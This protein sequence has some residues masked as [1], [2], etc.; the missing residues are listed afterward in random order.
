MKKRMYAS[1]ALCILLLIVSGSRAA[2]EEEEGALRGRVVS[3]ANEPLAGANVLILDTGRGAGTDGEGR[4]VISGLPPGDYVVEARYVGYG[5]ESKPV[6]IRAGET[7]EVELILHR[8]AIETEPVVVTGSPVATDPM[9][10]PQDISYIS[11]REKIRLESASLGKTIETIPGVYNM[12]AGSVAGKPIIRGHTGERIRILSDGIAQE[13]QQYGE[14]HAPNIDPFNSGRVEVIKGAA[15]LLYGSDALGGAVNLIPYRFHVSAGK[16][17]DYSGRLTAGYGSNN[18]EFM[19][20]LRFGFSRGRLGLN[21]SLVRRSAGDFHTPDREPYSVTQQRG[22]PKFTGEIDHTD[23]EQLNGAVSA[24]YLTPLGLLSLHYDH[25]FNENNFLLPTGLPIGLRLENQILTAKANMPLGQLILKP[26]FSYQ[27]NHRRAAR[28][29]DDREVLPDS[30]N[31]DLILDV[32]TARLDI[33]NV[34]TSGLSGTFG[35]EVKYYDHENV[36]LVPLQPTGHF[37]NYA[38]FCFEQWR[39]GRVTLDFGARF[40]YRSQEFLGSAANP[41]LPEDDETDYSSFSG[42]LGAAYGL[43]ENLT[44]A[45]NLGRGFRTP[46]FYNLYVYGYHGGVFAF[47]IGNPDLEAETSLD[48]SS[49]LR[50]RNAGLEAS[51]TLFQN[52]IDNYVFLYSA[53]DHPLAPLDEDFVFA[54]DQADAVLTGVDLSV[55]VTPLDWL[56]LSG[57]YSLIRSEFSGGAHE[58]EELPLMPADRI[59]GE[60]KLL[61]PGLPAVHSPYLLAGIRH[62]GE[63]EAAGPYEPFGQFDDGIGPDIPFGVCSTEAYTLFNLGGGFDLGIRQM[64]VNVDLEITNLLDEEYRDFLDTYKGYALSPGRSVNLKLNVPIPN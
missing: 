7:A 11:G 23:F 3:E 21:G 38:L 6:V 60:V 55:K 37:T 30:A 1:I 9:R 20:G 10:S 44:L 24:G 5:R 39:S 58:G 4:F 62:L 32:Y 46:S 25:Y 8:E 40:D 34:N 41:L 52:R 47:Q 28:P 45:A 42:A 63:R 50:F 59:T 36:G 15:S 2:G 57:S 22:D 14:R 53:P 16:P 33:E 12:S 17:M 29:G 56:V 43:T 49:S 35:A 61:L 64:E 31:V 26:R 48:A 27:R 18:E 19:S 13:Y 51:A 54:H